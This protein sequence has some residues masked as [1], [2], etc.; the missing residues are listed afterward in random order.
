MVDWYNVQFYNGWGDANTTALYDLIVDTG[1]D[2]QRIVLGV[3]THPG[4]G[5]SGHVPLEVLRGVVAELA[6][7]YG[8][9]FGGV[10]GWEFFNAGTEVLGR[11]NWEWV[12]EVGDVFVKPEAMAAQQVLGE[13]AGGA[14][15]GEAAARLRELRIPGNVTGR[16][17]E[18]RGRGEA[19]EGTTPNVSTLFPEEHVNRLI[20]LGFERPEAIAALEAMGG[21]VDRAAELLFSE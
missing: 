14:S 10:M 4:N 3:L 5:G 1:W 15:A 9:R 18:A 21:D 13:R 6:R 20:E 19:Q 8:E 12:R 7:R 2:P 17:R 16:E 11:E